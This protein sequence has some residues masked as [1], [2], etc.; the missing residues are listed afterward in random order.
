MKYHFRHKIKSNYCIP[1]LHIFKVELSTISHK[2]YNFRRFGF[3]DA[4]KS[5]QRRWL[6]YDAMRIW[7]WNSSHSISISSTDSVAL[8]RRW[9][10][11]SVIELW[12]VCHVRN[13]ARDCDFGPFETW[14]ISKWYAYVVMSHDSCVK[15]TCQP[16]PSMIFRAISKYV[17]YLTSLWFLKKINTVF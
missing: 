13:K 9:L 3:W 1:P 15:L 10:T 14:T 4:S 8:F 6:S 11:F 16:P 12:K 2:K 17:P 5:H 7:F